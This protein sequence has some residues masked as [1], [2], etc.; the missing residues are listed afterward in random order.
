[1]TRSPSPTCVHCVVTRA[2]S[3]L[4]RRYR[5]G[6]TLFTCA[7]QAP[8]VAMG[9]PELYALVS[10]FLREAAESSPGDGAV[11]VRIVKIQILAAAGAPRATRLRTLAVARHVDGSLIGGFEERYGDGAV[12]A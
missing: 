9:G 1:M 2:A 10:H 7:T 5:R 6:F 8:V 3:R 11:R 12:G 4:R